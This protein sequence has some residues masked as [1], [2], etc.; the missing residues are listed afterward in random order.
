[1]VIGDGLGYGN[2]AEPFTTAKSLMMNDTNSNAIKYLVCLTDGVWSNQLGAINCAKSCHNSGIE[3]IAL[4]FGGAD[5]GF[6]KAI[7]S[8]EDF[9]SFTGSS[10]DLGGSFSKI[11]RVIGD[12]TS[13]LR[14]IQGCESA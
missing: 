8:L 13:G 14:K 12:R 10:A 7:A 2:A 9:A 1:M 11:A 4:G 3:V 6:L 5:Y